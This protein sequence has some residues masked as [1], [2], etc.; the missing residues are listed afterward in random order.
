MK[1]RRRMFTRKKNADT[2]VSSA[3]NDYVYAPRKRLLMNSRKVHRFI[4]VASFYS[5][6]CLIYSTHPTIFVRLSFVRIVCRRRGWGGW[7]NGLIGGPIIHK[8]KGQS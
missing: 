1:T 4:A 6:K 3:R 7:R 8:G 5:F 2:E